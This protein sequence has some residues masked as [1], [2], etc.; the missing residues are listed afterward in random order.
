MTDAADPSP[1]TATSEPTQAPETTTAAAPQKPKPGAAAPYIWG[2]GRRKSSVA[3]VRIRAGD[4][5]FVINKR[6]VDE[7]FS[8]DKDRRVVRTPLEVAEMSKSM[9]VFVNV[10]GGGTS[11]QAGAVVLGLARALAKV[12]PELAPKLKE[13]NLLTRDPR[14]VERKKYGQPGARKRF[15]FSKR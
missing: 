2:T 10:G 14:K 3:R 4:G 1:D 9:D 12:D 5:Q 7:Y 8:L 6:K 11:G 15:Q 13:R